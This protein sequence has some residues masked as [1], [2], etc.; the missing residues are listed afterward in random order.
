MAGYSDEPYKL[1]PSPGPATLPRQPAAGLAAGPGGG[2]D[3][4]PLS[5]SLPSCW[6]V[7]PRPLLQGNWARTRLALF[8]GD[9]TLG[10]CSPSLRGPGDAWCPA[11]GQQVRVP[12]SVGR[13]VGAGF[14]P[15]KTVPRMFRSRSDPRPGPLTN[16]S[17][18]RS[19][20]SSRCPRSHRGPP[21]SQDYGRMGATPK[22]NQPF[23]NFPSRPAYPAPRCRAELSCFSG[24]RRGQPGGTR[25]AR[26]VGRLQL[27]TEGTS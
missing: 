24:A 5:P 9:G 4:T 17:V 23:A 15:S 16:P 21:R 3:T 14:P 26:R 19:P 2:H 25:T 13:R 7:P 20:Y 1:L 18:C 27:G 12:I 10:C 8:G 6:V 22:A 11:T